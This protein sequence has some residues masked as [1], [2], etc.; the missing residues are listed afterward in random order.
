[1]RTLHLSLEAARRLQYNDIGDPL[2]ASTAV[3]TQPAFRARL[4]GLSTFHRDL[5]QGTLPAVSFL[6]PKNL[7]SGHPGN[8]VLASFEG[9]VHT[10]VSAIR[11]H[12]KLWAH[13]AI[14]VTT[15]EGGGHFDSGYI[16]VLDFFGDGPRI[17]LLV[18]SPYARRGYV[19]H[20]YADH[21]SILKFIEQNWGLVPLSARSRDN[22]PNPV[23]DPADPYQPTNGPAVGDLRTLFDY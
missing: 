13:T 21:T 5:A 1:M 18:I 12:P 9:F 10:V 4:A 14:L 19:D 7:D 15:D 17:P 11:A 2:V 22:L 16:Q 23:M 20:T 6:V 8:S 3:M